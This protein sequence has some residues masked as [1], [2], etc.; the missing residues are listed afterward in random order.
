MNTPLTIPELFASIRLSG[1]EM[2]FDMERKKYSSTTLYDYPVCLEPA[3]C[4]VPSPEQLKDIQQPRDLEPRNDL[5]FIR[6]LLSL[7]DLREGLMEDVLRGLHATQS[8]MSFEVIGNQQEVFFQ[9]AL[10]EPCLAYFEA[11]FQAKY[12]HAILQQTPDPLKTKVGLSDRKLAFW[13]PQPKA[14]YHK[15]LTPLEEFKAPPVT[16]IV[17]VLSSFLKTDELGF[18][19]VLLFPCSE[20]NAWVENIRWLGDA[21]YSLRQWPT[22]TAQNPMQHPSSYLPLHANALQQ[23][24]HPD[25]PFFA[26]RIRFGGWVENQNKNRLFAGF[27]TFLAQFRCG[28]K[29]FHII[30][31]DDYKPH[32]GQKSLGETVTGRLSHGFGQLLNTHELLSLVDWPISPEDQTEITTPV[33]ILKH[34]MVPETMQSG[35]Y[36]LGNYRIGEQNI[37]VFIPLLDVR[38]PFTHPIKIGNGHVLLLGS[39]GSGKTTLIKDLLLQDIERGDCGTIL[40]SPHPDVFED[41]LAHIPQ[42]LIHRTVYSEALEPK[43]KHTLPIDFYSIGDDQ[44]LGRV[45]EDA[46]SCF[47]QALPTWG[48]KMAD[49][50]RNSL[51]V[52]FLMHERFAFILNLLDKGKNPQ[53]SEACRIRAMQLLK[54]H[55]YGLAVHFWRDDFPML[56]HSDVYPVRN[57]L[58]SLHLNKAMENLISPPKTKISIRDVMQNELVCFLNNRADILSSE[59]A[60]LLSDL[61]VMSIK[62]NALNHR[63]PEQKRPKCRVY[64]DEAQRLNSQAIGEMLEESRKANVDL[65]VSFSNMRKQDPRTIS[66]VQGAG[67]IIAFRSSREDF[68]KI[69][70]RFQPHIT[71]KEIAKLERGQAY[72]SVGSEVAY[73]ETQVPKPP[74]ISFA[75]QIKNHS[76]QNYGV[77]VDPDGSLDL[78]KYTKDLVRK[79]DQEK[80][81]RKRNFRRPHQF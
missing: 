36:R 66:A 23:K 6:V 17:E 53:K 68:M 79:G 54:E 18:Y 67:T 71:E 12:P 8:I 42:Q 37:P 62:N 70:D 2:V 64:I 32:L 28:D 1:H 69:K 47:S 80:K 5:R 58:S 48:P 33:Q 65:I 61:E 46:T 74:P 10:R 20:A 29:G 19:Q 55:G 43:E 30:S 34:K 9:F 26:S 59:G 73:F 57:K 31:S 60:T 21:E 52:L 72:V 44:N 75:N 3:F 63:I 78:E 38:V 24:A 11:A 25:K 56:S 13:E 81:Q 51:L 16:T 76:I 4:R 41:V 77:Q 14:L 45:A 27:Q 39:A 15:P 49:L 35:G 50:F 40:I 7:E 22:A